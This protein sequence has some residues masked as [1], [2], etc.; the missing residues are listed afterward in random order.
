M[1]RGT[2]QVQVYMREERCHRSLSINRF[3][4]EV[5]IFTFTLKSSSNYHFHSIAPINT[6]FLC[7]QTLGKQTA[8]A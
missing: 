1:Q 5:N 7:G 4:Q 6:R 3:C 8:C 2:T